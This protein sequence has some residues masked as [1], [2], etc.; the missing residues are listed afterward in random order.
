VEQVPEKIIARRK[1]LR[2]GSEQQL[3]P[4]E[5]EIGAP[6]KSPYSGDEFMCSLRLKSANWERVETVY[7]FDELQALLLALGYLEAILKRLDSS[8]NLRWAGGETGDLGIRI[9][10]FVDKY[11]HSGSL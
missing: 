9:P 10:T 2:G 1:Y 6:V 11:P 5:V 8:G 4:I 7:G 3:P